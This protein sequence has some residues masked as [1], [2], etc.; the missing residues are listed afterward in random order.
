MSRRGRSQWTSLE[1]RLT[2][3]VEWLAAALADA[4]AANEAL[5]VKLA[6]ERGYSESLISERDT[7]RI[8]RDEL[9]TKDE[10]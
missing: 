6:T 1:L 7:A 9:L 4:H 10:S 2:E 3:S 5:V 8:E